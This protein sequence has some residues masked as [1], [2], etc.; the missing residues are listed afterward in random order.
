[1]TTG[2]VFACKRIIRF[3]D[4][5]PAGIGF[6]PRLLEH[7]NN[8]VEDWFS[9]A[10]GM[11]FQEMHLSNKIRVPTCAL[12]VE[13]ISPARLGEVLDWQL[14]VKELGRSS[15]LLTVET[16]GPEGNLRLRANPRL[17]WCEHTRGSPKSCSIPERIRAEMK[18]FL[19][20]H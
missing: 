5:D 3:A 11:S 8:T 14:K 19:V 10:I 9:D 13:F 12:T 15:I 18:R 7:V 6:Y 4:C 2:E 17:V 16:Y 20:Q 1:M